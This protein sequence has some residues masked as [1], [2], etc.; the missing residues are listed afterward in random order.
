LTLSA[1][2]LLAVNGNSVTLP[3]PVPGYDPGHERAQ[4]IGQSAAGD[5]Y[6]YDKAVTNRGIRFTVEATK[7]QKNAFITWYDTHAEGALNT[8][9]FTDHYGTAHTDCRFGEQ[10]TISK[11]PSARYSIGLFVITTDDTD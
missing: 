9:T 4:V 6:V 5:Y 8:F 11:L 10:P 2:I 3:A 7:T 1:T